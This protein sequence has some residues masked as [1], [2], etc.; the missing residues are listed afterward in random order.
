VETNEFSRLVDIMAKLRS[1][2]G[3]PWD[4]EQTHESLRQHLLEETYEVLEAI[5]NDSD[6]LV[7]ELGDLLLQVVFHA[8]IAAEENRFDV[9]DVIRSITE[10]L[11]RRHPHVFGDEVVN[12]AE[13]QTILWEKTKLKKEGKKSAIDGVPQALPALVRA[14]RIQ[15]KAATVGFDWPTIE[16]VW[17]KLDEEL[18]ELKSAIEEQKPGDIEE[19]L[20]DVIFSL[21]NIARFLQCNPEDALRKTIDKF[22]DRFYRV[23]ETLKQEHRSIDEASLE[24]MDTIWNHIK[25]QDRKTPS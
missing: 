13:E 10:K 18:D 2:G 5:D 24:E 25:A 12:S 9:D 3:C 16:P 20:G 1:P 21:V 14:Y 23:E 19:E 15:N 6:E 7:S 4:I 22:K 17:E 11:I 8:Q